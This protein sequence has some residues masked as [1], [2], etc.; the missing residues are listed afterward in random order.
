[1]NSNNGRPQEETAG[2]ML[3]LD[4]VSMARSIPMFQRHSH[5][6]RRLTKGAAPPFER[7]TPTVVETA[8]TYLRA[9]F[10]VFPLGAGKRPLANCVR[11]RNH[12]CG[13]PALCRCR[14]GL[15]HSFYAAT[16]DA[17]LVGGW[18]A[19]NPQWNLAVRTGPGSGLV[20]LDIDYDKGG[21][22][23]LALLRAEGL[24]T[25]GCPYVL[26]GSGMSTH[27]YFRYPPVGTVRCSAGRLGLGVDVRGDL[28]YAVAAGSIHPKT[29]GRYALVGD[30][31]ELPTWPLARISAPRPGTS[32]HEAKAPSSPGRL[33]AAPAGGSRL[34]PRRL[35]AWVRMVRSA[36]V[37][38]RRETLFWA[39]SRLAEAAGPAS[40][41][42]QAAQALAAAGRVV[43]LPADEV[44]STILDGLRRTS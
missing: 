8:A 44:V 32:A 7:T 14:R 38:E 35:A 42:Q 5:S 36:E 34:T 28:G 24:S 39:A 6:E 40:A 12:G 3:N 27:F 4:S 11:C 43:D 33:S 2:A 26:S 25:A 1:M 19:Q 31:S 41:R 16:T 37:G 22:H 9:G 30:L 13:S 20:V 21:G 15:C 17:T 29:G 18:F 23:T 10:E